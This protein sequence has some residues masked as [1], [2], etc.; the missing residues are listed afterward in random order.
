MAV[1][2]NIIRRILKPRKHA[3]FHVKKGTYIVVA[4]SSVTERRIQVLDI[5]KGGLACVYAGLKSELSDTGILKLL[6]DD[7]TYLENVRY[8]TASDVLLPGVGTKAGQTRRRGVKFKW[9]GL[10]D[11]NNL[12]DLIRNCSVCKV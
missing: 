4:S 12:Q 2:R 1:K 9:F 11:K 8:E 3:R 5:S 10:I 7:M 6:V